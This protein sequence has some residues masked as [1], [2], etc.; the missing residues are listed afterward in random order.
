MKIFHIICV[1]A[2]DTVIGIAIV[3]VTIG[4]KNQYS[5]KA[6]ILDNVI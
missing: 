6:K 5:V 3:K 4:I 2:A 1:G